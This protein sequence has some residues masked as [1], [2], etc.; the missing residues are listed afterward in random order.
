[1][2]KTVDLRSDTLTLPTEEMREAMA[3]AEV[4]DEQYSEDPTVNRLQ[5]MGSEFWLTTSLATISR[6]H[7]LFKWLGKQ[8][9]RAKASR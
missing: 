6:V 9:K 8:R 5:G 7:Q 1:M 4:G 2:F 3:K